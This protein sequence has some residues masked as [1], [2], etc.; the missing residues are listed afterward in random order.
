M[1]REV[2]TR[3]ITFENFADWY[4]YRIWYAPWLEL[5]DLTKWFS[6]GVQGSHSDST[7]GTSTEPDPDIQS[8]DEDSLLDESDASAADDALALLK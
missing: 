3:G 8:D 1:I 6:Y 4:T 5:L 2:D 7:P